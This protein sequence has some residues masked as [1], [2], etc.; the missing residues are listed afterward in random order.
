MIREVA[1][2]EEKHHKICKCCPVPLFMLM[3]LLRGELGKVTE[4]EHSPHYLP[5]L[6]IRNFSTW[7]QI[8]LE[9]VHL[10]MYIACIKLLN[11]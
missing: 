1:T 5:F 6:L 3:S 11:C 10:G 2:I 9:K 4:S 8:Y 7:R